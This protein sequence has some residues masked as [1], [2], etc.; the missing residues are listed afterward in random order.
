M[1]GVATSLSFLLFIYGARRIQYSTVGFLQYISPTLQLMIGIFIYGEPFASPQLISF[2][3][4]WSAVII[5][6]TSGFI[7]YRKRAG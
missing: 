5:Y 1:S 2:G 7:A 6:S 4:V 3:C